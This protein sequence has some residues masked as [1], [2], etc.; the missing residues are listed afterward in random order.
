[1]CWER[2]QL[3]FIWKNLTSSNLTRKHV[4]GLAKRVLTHPGYLRIVVMAFTKINKILLARK[5]E[6]KEGKISDE[7]I[8]AKFA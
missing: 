7:A 1:M 4:S 3:L 2:N 5:K 8:F 6:G